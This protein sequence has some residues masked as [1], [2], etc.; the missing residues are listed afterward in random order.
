MLQVVAVVQDNQDQEVVEDLVAEVRT[1]A[2]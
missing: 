1:E 2:K